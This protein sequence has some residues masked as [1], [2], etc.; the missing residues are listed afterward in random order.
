[1]NPATP[2]RVL[3]IDDD[4]STRFFL[5]MALESTDFQVFEA[6]SGEEGIVQFEQVQPA[7]VFVDYKMP[8]M[9]GVMCCRKLRA[10]SAQVVL[11]MLSG[12]E[13][14]HMSALAVD[15]GADR[16]LNKPTNWVF[17]ARTAREMLSQ[18]QLRAA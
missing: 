8:G 9:D 1:M 7:L 12:R 16:F 4:E 18:A 13:D 3:V 15:A 6:A 17:M 5:K 14:P 11:I 2:T 10:L